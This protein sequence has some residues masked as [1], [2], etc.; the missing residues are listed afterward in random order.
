MEDSH[1]HNGEG[2]KYR[3]IQQ[4]DFKVRVFWDVAM[5]EE[6]LAKGVW[7]RKGAVVLGFD[8]EYTRDHE[9]AMVQL[10]DERMAVIVKLMHID[11]RADTKERLPMPQG[12]RAL[13]ESSAIFKAG[14]GV[15]NDAQALRTQYPDLVMG[16]LL[17]VSAAAVGFGIT[18]GRRGLGDLS[19]DILGVP[20]GE[21]HGRWAFRRMLT[22]E[23]AR[24][25]SYDAWLGLQIALAMHSSLRTGEDEGLSEWCLRAARTA[26]PYIEEQIY[27]SSS[28]SRTVDVPGNTSSAPKGAREKLVQKRKLNAEKG[29]VR[30]RLE[31]V[32]KRRDKL[33]SDEKALDDALSALKA[34]VADG[35]DTPQQKKQKQD[36]GSSSNKVKASIED[37]DGMQMNFF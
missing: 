24:Y 14:V 27:S 1:N 4:P 26:E 33:K 32:R 35:D 13:L 22:P 31:D 20:K 15:Y 34:S 21:S 25:A 10:S 36:S 17:D 19:L 18:A 29:V 30:A 6:F 2:R 37:D 5:C 28:N 16:G 7:P 23:Q 11:V 9:V 3:S 12:V 8:A